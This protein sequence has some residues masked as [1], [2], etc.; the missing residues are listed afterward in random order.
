MAV[1][2]LLV[3]EV[4]EMEAVELSTSLVEMLRLMVEMKLL[5]SEEVEREAAELSRF[6]A[7]PFCLMVVN[8]V[9]VSVVVTLNLVPPVAAIFTSVVALSPLRAVK[10]L[11]ASAEAKKLPIM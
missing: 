7:E 10:E 2:L 6:L 11:L 3:S 8:M 9:P 1:M 4:V 5:V